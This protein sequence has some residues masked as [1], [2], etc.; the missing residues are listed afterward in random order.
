MSEYHSLSCCLS[1]VPVMIKE[2]R[3]PGKAWE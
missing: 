3:A 2:A 1:C